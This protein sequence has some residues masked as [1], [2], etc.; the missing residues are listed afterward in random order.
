MILLQGTSNLLKYE[1]MKD[2]LKDIKEIELIRPTDLNITIDIKEDGKS[3]EEN[4]I[5]KAKAY[6]EVT[7]LPVITEDSGLYIGKFK[8]YEQPS[9]YVKRVNGKENLT[10]TEILNYYIDKLNSYG[11]SSLAHYYTGVCIIDENGNI[12]SD[13]ITETPFLLTTNINSANSI[14]GGILEPI[15]Y[16][17][18]SNKYFSER[19]DEEKKLHYKDLD[20]K[21][22][23][24]I[25]KYLLKGEIDYGRNI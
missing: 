18:D 2:R 16:D 9:L 21:Y 4:A 1:L 11:G 20:D 24:L 3:V 7:H 13:T 15:S 22:K 12:Y 23:I 10:D 14:K 5:K 6:Y 19:T 8:D 25:K 17:I